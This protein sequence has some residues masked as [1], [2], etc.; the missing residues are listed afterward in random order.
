[1]STFANAVNNQVTTTTNGMKARKASGNACTDL[2]FQIGASRGKNIIPAFV[3]ALVENTDYA[4]RIAQWARDVRGGAGERQLFKDILSYLDKND[5]ELALRVMKNVPELGRWDDLLIE[6]ENKTLEYRAAQMF[7]GAIAGGNGL[8]AKW[9]PRK[10]PWA[11]KLRKHWEMTPKKYR[12]FIVNASDTV[13]QKMCAKQWDDINFSHVPSLAASRYRTAFYRN[14]EAKFAEYLEK[15]K[16]GDTS[17]KVNA[18]AVYPYDVL[19]HQHSA[20]QDHVI[21]QWDA[22]ENFI[23]DA[24][25]LPMVDVSGSMCAS[26]GNSTSLSC[27]DVAVSLGLYCAEKNTGKFKDLVLTFSV[28]PQ[29][30]SLKGNIIQKAQQLRRTDWGMNTDLNRAFNQ[31]LATAVH[32]NVPTEEMPE[33]LVI[34]SD[35]QFDASQDSG[36]GFYRRQSP[37]TPFNEDAIEMIDRKYSEAGYSR[38]Q[39][40]FWNLNAYDNCP[41][42]FDKLGTAMVS[43][44]SPSIMKAVLAADFDDFT[45]ENI[46]RQT[47][48]S[49]RYN[50]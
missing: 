33:I 50:Y 16:A 31:I 3:A 44:F 20:T 37:V 47:I 46:M 45:P 30:V 24:N 42:E 25:I 48:M 11:L 34:L 26:A 8:A 6:Y 36:N 39:V 7:K 9:A 1:M 49:D 15:L 23:G 35:M 28:D 2:F 43:G 41:V 32:N 19:K 21:A 4:L 5:S 14:A 27:M 17:V 29:L 12:Q 10:G 40:V 18:G 22:L 38:P 13:E